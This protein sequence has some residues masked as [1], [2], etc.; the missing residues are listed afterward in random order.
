MKSLRSLFASLAPHKR[1][2]RRFYLHVGGHKT[3]TSAQQVWFARNTDLMRKAGLAYPTEIVGQHG[4]ALRIVGSWAKD[5][6]SWDLAD[7]VLM[8]QY[9]EFLQADPVTDIFVSSE[10]F[11]RPEFLPGLKF[12]ASDLKDLGLPCTT[13][14]FIR[15]QVDHVSSYY[16]QRHKLLEMALPFGMEALALQRMNMSDWNLRRD[17]HLSLGFT[18]LIGVFQRSP[19]RPVVEDL[20]TLAGLRDRFAN[21]ADFAVEEVNPPLGELG[22]LIGMH[23]ARF[24]ESHGIYLSHRSKIAYSGCVVPLSV[25]AKDRKFIGPNAE[26]RAQIRA[27]YAEGNRALARI[28]PEDEAELLLTERLPDGPVSPRSVAELEP[29][30]FAELEAMFEAT[31]SR[32]LTNSAIL[33]H[34]S[35]D[36]IRAI[37]RI[38]R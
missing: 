18:P 19:S 26:E 12:I 38:G 21:N 7:R 10:N 31:R 6:E 23:I 25:A 22:V 16:A 17:L 2:D 1:K 35:A 27:R 3:A 37:P 8:T 34:L 36:Q 20:I 4:N 29:S 33:V 9:A 30:R 11:N 24:I 5:P 32:M 13:L 28:L 15:N 14:M